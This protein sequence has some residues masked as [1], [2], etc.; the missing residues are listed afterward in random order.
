MESAPIEKENKKDEISM[1]LIKNIETI[2]I[3][4]ETLTIILGVYIV[5]LND[6]QKRIE[7]KG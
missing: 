2:N 6:Y 7:N 5:V 1:Y 4:A 3:W